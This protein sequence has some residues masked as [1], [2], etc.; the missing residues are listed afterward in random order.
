MRD[1]RGAFGFSK[2]VAFLRGAASPP[3]PDWA[4]KLAGFGSGAARPADWWRLLGQLLLSSP[5]GLLEEHARA[6]AHQTYTLVRLS[7]KGAAWLDRADRG[8]LVLPLPREMLRFET[9]ASPALAR[10]K[11]D[12]SRGEA[13]GLARLAYVPAGGGGGGAKRTREGQ[14]VLEGEEDELLKRLHGV[15]DQ[16]AKREGV[17]LSLVCQVIRA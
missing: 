10:R 12:A 8:P 11:R 4:R 2:Y 13:E 9:G 16:L 3:L 6:A 5:A 1:L 7:R 15:R 17:P 14:R